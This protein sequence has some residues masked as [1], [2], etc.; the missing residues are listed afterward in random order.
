AEA[1]PARTPTPAQAAQQQRMRDCNAQAATRTLR[2]APRQEFMRTCLSN[3]PA[4]PAAAA[5]PAPTS[6]P[7]SGAAG[8]AP[9]APA[10]TNPAPAATR[11]TP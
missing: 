4:D 7:V 3:R 9:T 1:R 11:R 5:I 2:G 6:P 10:T 8:R